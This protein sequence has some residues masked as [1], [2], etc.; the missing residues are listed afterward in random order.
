MITLLAMV[1]LAAP[2]GPAKEVEFGSLGTLRVPDGCTHVA[3]QGVD[4]AVGYLECGDSLSRVKYDIG[5]ASPG[6][7]PEPRGWCTTIE[8]SDR[9]P[10]RLVELPID[11]RRSLFVCELPPYYDDPALLV[12]VPS[13]TV[14]FYTAVK[15]PADAS[16]LLTVA[17]AFRPR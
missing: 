8:E 11:T 9:R 10:L 14:S 3:R 16:W 4:S 15:A 6:A 12:A 5:F 2:G 7:K 17:M 1:L 13:P